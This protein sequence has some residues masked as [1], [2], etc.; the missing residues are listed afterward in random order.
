MSQKQFRINHHFVPECYLKRWQ[1]YKKKIFTYRVLVSH[2]KVPVWRNYSV[3]SIAY[4]KHLYTHVVSGCE[5]DELEIWFD[6]EFESNANMAIEKAVNDQKLSPS[7]WKTLIRFLAAQDVRTPARLFDH[8]ESTSKS[9]PLILDNILKKLK[10]KI[11]NG[12]FG[13]N[14]PQ[15]HAVDPELFPL[16]VTPLFEEGSEEGTLKVETYA[17]RS[18]WIF[19]I[20][21]A[22][23]RT[24]K[25]LHTHKW[26]IV[27]PAEGYSW[28]TS[29]NP[30]VK[31]NYY[32]HG[33]FDLKGGWGMPKGNI[34]FPLG[35]EHAMLTQIGPW[36]MPK[37]TRLPIG[38]TE[39][40][41]KYIAT[42]A[43][44]QIFSIDKNKKI[45]ALRKRIA[46]NHLFK[47]EKEEIRLWHEIN[48]NLEREYYK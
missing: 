8:L 25:I 19:S 10:K 37:G 28:P 24:S 27:K 5:S 42:N 21:L 34:I 18:S 36:S 33:S 17:G 13:D 38:L 39:N 22:L 6:R 3:S 11:D 20:K 4:Q 16:K 30:V 7:D 14:K 9:L 43:H 35:P 44:R 47:Q 1:N 15:N 23:N 12:K 26:R 41:I 31:L 40:I 46:N 2:N 32:R 29:D 48:A 45:P